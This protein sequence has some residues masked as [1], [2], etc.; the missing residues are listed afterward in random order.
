MTHI[1]RI[2]ELKS[3]TYRSAADKRETQLK[4]MP[5]SL[6]K[7]LPKEV[8]D[9][10]QRLRARADEVEKDEKKL[11]K[12]L[13][14][15]KERADVNKAKKCY[16]EL[17]KV[18][19]FLRDDIYNA[20]NKAPKTKT[21]KQ[22]TPRVGGLIPSGSDLRLIE[23]GCA[24]QEACMCLGVCGSPSLIPPIN[25]KDAMDM[26]DKIAKKYPEFILSAKRDN[27]TGEASYYSKTDYSM[28]F[29]P[30]FKKITSEHADF[31]VVNF[32]L[33]NGGG[34]SNSYKGYLIN[35]QRN[36]EGYYLLLNP[37]YWKK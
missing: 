26:L 1:L 21:K 4:A 22:I 27:S 3:S 8:L 33:W 12:K 28:H 35:G 32:T 13:E 5:P 6:M 16:I 18:Q 36:G 2:D 31:E 14:R 19:D 24:C 30:L 37:S 34:F 11:E 23:Y 17:C 20:Y 7:K 15:K 9:M 29:T 10:P 25:F